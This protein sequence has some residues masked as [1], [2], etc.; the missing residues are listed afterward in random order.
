V[1]SQLRITALH[2]AAK[3]AGGPAPLRRYLNVSAVCLAMWMSGGAVLPDD[4][5]L[6]LVDLI[7][8]RDLSDLKSKDGPSPV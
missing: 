6:K 7:V 2:R 3:I 4:A 8:E 1:K 5:F